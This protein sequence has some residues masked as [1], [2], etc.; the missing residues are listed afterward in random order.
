MRRAPLRYGF[1]IGDD[2]EASIIQDDDLLTYSE[3]IERKDSN[4][5]LSAMKSEMDS[6]YS[7][8]VWTLMD[9]P[10]GINPIGYN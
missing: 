3:A 4:K 1:V 5:W 9:P 8:Q 2:N 7:N 6:M 10:N